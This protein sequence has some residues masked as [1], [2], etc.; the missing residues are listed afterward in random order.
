L[1]DE[2]DGDASLYGGQKRMSKD[3]DWSES[4]AVELYDWTLK[5]QLSMPNLTGTAFWVFKD[6]ATPIRPENPIPYMNQKGV[7]Q[8]DLTPKEVFY[9]VQSYWAETPMVHIYGH[10]WPIRWGE[11]GA[12]SQ[13]K[14]YS[15]CEKVELFVD[16][17]SRGV[18]LRKPGEFPAAGLFWEVQLNEGFNEVKAV[19]FSGRQVIE[20]HLV[21]NYQSG[22]WGEIHEFILKEESI[23]QSASYIIV[24]AVDLNGKVCLDAN[25]LVEFNVA[26]QATL[27]QNQ[28][29]ATG[30]RKI[31]LANGMARIKLF[32]TGENYTVSIQAPQIGCA[33]LKR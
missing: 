6:F 2:R 19:A 24:T 28:G 1:A 7:V 22:T 23:D 20:D 21:W 15:N 33:L 3:G 10:S 17:K 5:E 31:Q 13:V 25:T 27:M 29:T 32:K 26:G 16:G 9:V 8:R 18:K 14:V 30:S 4:Y 11:A 12:L